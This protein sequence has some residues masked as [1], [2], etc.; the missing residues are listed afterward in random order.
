[1]NQMLATRRY[2]ATQQARS[3]RDQEADVFR[4][5]NYGLKAALNGDAI[6]RTRAIADNRRLWMA[7]E[8]AIVHPANQ[9]PQALRVSILSLSRS[10]QREMEGTEPDI[11]FLIDMND[12]MISGLSGDP[13]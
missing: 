10:I 9:L 6:E 7:V 12:Q 11:A 8:G 5:V 3:L 13:G 1:M 4:R 2:G